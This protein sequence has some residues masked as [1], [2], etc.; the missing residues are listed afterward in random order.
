MCG[1][2]DAENAWVAVGMIVGS[3]AVHPVVPVQHV[4]VQPV[5][6]HID[7]DQRYR[8][9]PLPGPPTEYEPPAPIIF[10]TQS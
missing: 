9:I 1:G 8:N 2:V 6:R 3:G 4:S 10:S 5:Y 7:Q